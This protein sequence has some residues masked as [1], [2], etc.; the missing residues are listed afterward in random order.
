MEATVKSMARAIPAVT[1]LILL[2]ATAPEAQKRIST[3]EERSQAVALTKKLESAPFGKDAD[4]NHAW[5]AVLFDEITDVS[6]KVCFSFL[7]PLLGKDKNYGNKIFFHA[8]F[9]QGAF[10]I[11]N[12]D[13]AK[14]DYAIYLAGLEGALRYYEAIR[15]E[16]PKTKWPLLDTLLA[17]RDAG[18]LGDYV[19]EKMVACG[20]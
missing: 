2:A 16:K 11:E 1:V 10:M 5:L 17:K 9:S 3:A 7:E 18:Q 19:R 14:D 6:V 4:K 12:P 15:K 20:G 8:L 13:K